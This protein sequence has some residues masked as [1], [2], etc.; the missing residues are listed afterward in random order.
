M[1]I[2]QL[3][4]STITDFQKRSCLSESKD[5]QLA[6]VVFAGQVSK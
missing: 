6:A 5:R 4:T 2:A 3:E 1:A